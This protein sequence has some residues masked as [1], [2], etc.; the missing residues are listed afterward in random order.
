MLNLKRNVM[1][2]ENLD[3]LEKQVEH[4]GFGRNVIGFT[5]EFIDL[6]VALK[7][8]M[9]KGVKAFTLKYAYMVGNDELQAVLWFD[10][11]E[12]NGFYYFNSYHLGVLG[13]NNEQVL[14]RNFEVKVFNNSQIKRRPLTEADQELPEKHIKN[15]NITVREAYNLL[16]GGSVCK[17]TPDQDNF[18]KEVWLLLDF[19]RFKPNGQDFE[20]ITFDPEQGYDFD[21]V[22]ELEKFPI[23]DLPGKNT[24][25]GLIESLKKGNLSKAFI[26]IDGVAVEHYLEVDAIN[27]CIKVSNSAFKVLSPEETAAL[28]KQGHLF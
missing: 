26:N 22:R 9:S 17:E 24:D 18:I 7:E 11:S 15:R 19:T 21:L 6:R 20:I 27:K 28:H 8:N 14:A 2:E 4:T 25:S 3:F 13:W 10:R 12:K 23:E 16:C 5:N 1:V